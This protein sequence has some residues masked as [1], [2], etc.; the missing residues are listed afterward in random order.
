MS[1][2]KSYIE[3]LDNWIA[4]SIIYGAICVPVKIVA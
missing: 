1:N 3:L 4:Y 2:T